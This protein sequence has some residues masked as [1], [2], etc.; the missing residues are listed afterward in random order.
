MREIIL[1]DRYN[2]ID[3]IK[4]AKEEWV[5]NL[6]IILGMS[7]DDLHSGDIELLK[8]YDIQVWDHLDNG[9]VEVIQNNVL[10]GKWYAPELVLKYDEK[11]NLYYEIHLDYNSILD[12]EIH[13]DGEKING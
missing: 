6:L 9:D 13:S 12:N 7:H 10:V 4:E 8:K 2:T 11:N 3:I 5:Y 1:S